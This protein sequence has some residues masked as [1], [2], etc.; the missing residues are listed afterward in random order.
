MHP[1]NL[2][3]VSNHKGPLPTGEVAGNGCK[4]VWLRRIFR[5]GSGSG[6]HWW[7]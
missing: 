3:L 6:L 2:G 4:K 1:Q 7:H 5:E